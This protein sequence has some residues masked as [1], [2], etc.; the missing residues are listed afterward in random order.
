MT[1]DS[2]FG[3]TSLIVGT[4]LVGRFKASSKLCSDSPKAKL[5]T[6]SDKLTSPE[7]SFI[8]SV[9]TFLR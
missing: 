3:G 1:Y 2:G 4:L 9:A 6:D 8:V 7:R 5:L